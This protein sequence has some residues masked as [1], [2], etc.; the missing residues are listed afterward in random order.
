MLQFSN[1]SLIVIRRISDGSGYVIKYILQ[2][3][4]ARWY[5]QMSFIFYNFAPNIDLDSI[6]LWSS[7][8]SVM[9]C[10]ACFYA[11]SLSRHLSDFFCWPWT[12]WMLFNDKIFNLIMATF[13]CQRLTCK[14]T[15]H[16]IIVLVEKNADTIIVKPRWKSQWGQ[17]LSI[18]K[19]FTRDHYISVTV[20]IL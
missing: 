3:Q 19:S 10:Y 9:L 14:L 20:R 1:H 7:S 17:N 4:S 5:Y 8:V 13:L 16:E 11:D 18:R 2:F 15:C 12:P 6:Q